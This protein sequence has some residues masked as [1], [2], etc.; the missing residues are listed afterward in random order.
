[1]FAVFANAT[2]PDAIRVRARFMAVG[3][4]APQ[5]TKQGP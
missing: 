5:L 2:S 4:Q 1:M 3:S